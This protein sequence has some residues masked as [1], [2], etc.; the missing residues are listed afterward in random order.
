VAYLRVG[1][2]LVGLTALAL[3]RGRVHEF[4]AG[5]EAFSDA[6]IADLRNILD[7][8]DDPD[9]QRSGNF[10]N[11]SASE[12]YAVWAETYDSEDNPLIDVDRATLAPLIARHAP[13]AALDAA[14]GTGRWAAFLAERGFDVLGVDES[15]EML[16]RV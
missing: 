8:W 9:L 16:E 10:G 3:L 11:A 7:H 14:C 12:G 2:V 1:D 15:P 5:G 6:R 4:S 13:G